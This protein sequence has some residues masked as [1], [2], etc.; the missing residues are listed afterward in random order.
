MMPAFLFDQF[1]VTHSAC[2]VARA[3]GRINFIGEHTDY[4]NGFVLPAAIDKYI[5][6][7]LERRADDIIHL[8]S[9]DLQQEY[10]TSLAALKTAPEVWPNYVLGV[11][12]QLLKAGC[13]IT[14]FNAIITGD[15]PP[16]AGLSSSAALECAAIIALNSQ[17]KLELSPVDM[18]KMAQQ[19]E[20]DFVGV[21]CGIMDQYASMFGKAGHAIKLDCSNLAYEYIPVQMEGVKILLFDTQVKHALA[22]SE[23]NKRREECENGVAII[24]SKYPPVKSLRDATM[25]MVE[26]CLN[27]Q[28]KNIYHRCKYVVAENQR[29]LDACV[30]LKNRNIEAFGE[31]MFTTH[32]GL[33]KLYDVSCPELDFLVACAA[34]APGILGARMMGGGFGGCTINLVKEAQCKEITEKIAGQYFSAFGKQMEYYEANTSDGASLV[35]YSPHKTAVTN[36]VAGN[37]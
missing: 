17:F 28:D 37:E 27:D 20:H 13:T 19:A 30:D 24:Q 36:L 32:N 7:A 9:V 21:K 35:A 3:P 22:S 25:V 5:Y 26:N 16:G 8:I 1:V 14:G 11:V 34:S 6:V 12:A 4:N 31:K 23:Y 2:T 33:S 10:S 29:L 18:V 15:I